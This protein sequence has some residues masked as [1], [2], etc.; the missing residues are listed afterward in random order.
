[1]PRLRS[2][3]V[4]VTLA[5]ASTLVSCNGDEGPTAPSNEASLIGAWSG[6]MTVNRTGAAATTCDLRVTLAPVDPNVLVG[7]WQADCSNGASGRETVTAVTVFDL[8]T[9]NAAGTS[10]VLDGCAWAMSAQALRGR[11]SGEWTRANNSC[12]G[13]PIQ[14]GTINLRKV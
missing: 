4:F 10:Q 8:V 11:L 12:A 7:S 9:L 6:T 1:M 5:L 14:G 3:A 13:S 2:A